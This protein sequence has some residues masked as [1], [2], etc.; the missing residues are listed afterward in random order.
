MIRSFA[1]L[2]FFAFS[3]SVLGAEVKT[4]VGKVTK[5]AA[6]PHAYGNYDENQKG[7]LTIYVEGLPNGCNTGHPRVVIGVDHPLHDSVLSIALMAKATGKEVTL[8]YFDDCTIR[9]ES[10]DLAYITL[11]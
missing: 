9:S 7:R 10:W 1:F 5:V 6:F 11:H 8:A 4:H 2:L 3:S